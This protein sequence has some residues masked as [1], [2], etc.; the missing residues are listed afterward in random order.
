MAE[1]FSCLQSTERRC[2]QMGGRSLS[3]GHHLQSK[4]DISPGRRET[5][6]READKQKQKRAEGGSGS[7]AP[8][9]RVLVII[10]AAAPHGVISQVMRTA[11]VAVSACVVYGCY[12]L[13]RLT[14]SR[15]SVLG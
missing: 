9:G 15:G 10:T 8:R 1:H 6:Q 7:S 12:R 2:S 13:L 3:L 4:W 14:R 5:R 11:H